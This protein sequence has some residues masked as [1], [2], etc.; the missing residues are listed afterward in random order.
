MSVVSYEVDFISEQ[1][2]HRLLDS[3]TKAQ[4]KSAMRKGCRWG[5][6]IIA[7][8]VKSGTPSKTGKLVR[9]LKVRAI[10]R[11][12]KGVGVMT[13]FGDGWYAG[14]TFYGAFL[15]F[16]HRIGKRRGKSTRKGGPGDTRKE[17]KGSH[18][19]QNAAK[20]VMGVAKKVAVERMI[21]ELENTVPK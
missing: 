9:S 20:R 17:I 21:Y 16:G 19:M 8:S 15:E 18:F 12:R 6:K 14:D 10:K 7:A 1:K 13:V 2:L 4:G 3:Y 5:A 11:S